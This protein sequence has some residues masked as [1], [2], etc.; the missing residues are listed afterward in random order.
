MDVQL[1]PR[2]F[3]CFIV[4][5]G[6][7]S[8]WIIPLML[9][10]R[11]GVFPKRLD[12]EGIMTRAGKRIPW[13]DLKSVKHLRYKLRGGRSVMEEYN[14]TSSQGRVQ[15]FSNRIFNFNEVMTYVWSKVPQL[16]KTL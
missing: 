4:F 16:E 3:G 12:D 7:I 9:R 5:L 14:F 8:F 2:P 15:F 10:S 1:T 13:S 6:L 11:E